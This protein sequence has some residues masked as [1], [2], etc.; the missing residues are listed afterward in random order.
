MSKSFG[1]TRALSDVSFDVAAGEVHA[2]VGQNGSGKSTLIKLLAGVHEAEEDSAVEVDGAL[3]PLGHPAASRAAGFRFVHQDLALVN[4][5]SVVEN[6][7]LGRGFS[8]GFGGRIRWGRERREAQAMMREL[9]FELD[10][11]RPVGELAQAE[12]TGVAIARALWDWEAGARVLVLDEPTSA[13]PSAEVAVLFASIRRVVARGLGV[14][15]VSHRLDEIFAIAD[16]VTVLRDGSRV[17]TFET[18]QMTEAQL[19]S[20]MIGGAVLRSSAPARPREGTPVLEARGLTGREVRGV[21]FDAHAGEVL[22][23]V[24]LTG[25]GREEILQLLFGALPRHGVVRVAGSDVRPGSPRA[26]VK[27]GMALVPA[28]RHRQGLILEM[29]V[30]ENCTLT[31]LRPFRTRLGAIRRRGELA[32]VSSWL[33]RLDVRPRDPTRTLA[34]LSGGNQQKVVLA[35]WLRLEPRVILLDEPTQGIDV[36]AKALIHGLIRKAAD[37]G[38]AVIVATSDDEEIRDVCD[39]AYVLRDGELVAVRERSE[40]SIDELGL[41]KHGGTPAM[42]GGAVRGSTG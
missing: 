16:Q 13:L 23:F 36:G 3:V 11:R 25:S 7:G 37:D 8:T 32:E 17:G 34:Q 39:L 42:P 14:L 40:L 10:V 38:A 22:G 26:S 28:N 15:Y 31:D 21:D 41:L 9:G 6:L 24:G 19:V 2:L 18:Q 29:S 27:R 33:T 4:D 35:K 12:R 5:L 20:L 30:R 1:A